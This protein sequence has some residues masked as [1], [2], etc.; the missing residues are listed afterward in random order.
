M[1]YELVIAGRIALE[2]TLKILK[3]RGEELGSYYS[4]SFLKSIDRLSEFLLTEVQKEILREQAP[5][6][7]QPMGE[8]GIFAALWDLT[9]SLEMGMEIDLRLIPVFQ[10]TIELSEYYDINPYRLLSGGS[11]ILVCEHGG[12]TAARLK[13]R[14]IACQVFGRVLK[15]RKRLIYNGENRSFLDRPQKD[16]LNKIL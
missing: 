12:R 14:G 1:E 7:I 5:I 16:E 8:G 10:E 4:A 3:Y 13:E 9:N 15:S 2:G 6:E 11:E